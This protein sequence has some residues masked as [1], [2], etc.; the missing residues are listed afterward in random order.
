MMRASIPLSFS[1]SVSD[2]MYFGGYCS[3]WNLPNIFQ[4]DIFISNQTTSL[5]KENIFHA[6]VLSFLH[7]ADG[8]NIIS[9]MDYR[10]SDSPCDSIWWSHNY[11]LYSSIP[12]AVGHSSVYLMCDEK[13]VDLGGY[14]TFSSFR[15]ILKFTSFR[16]LH[17]CTCT[18]V[19]H[20]SSQ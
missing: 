8:L 17:E 13:T 4:S 3:L 19:D 7:N 11:H 18:K 2:E 16:C 5:Q 15:T 12:S 1:F 10:L 9:I 20:C 14:E 6:L